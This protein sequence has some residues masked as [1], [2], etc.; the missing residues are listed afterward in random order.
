M[1]VKICG[2]SDIESARVAVKYGT[3]AIGFVFA[4]SK[5]KVTPEQAREIIQNIPFH[6]DKIGVFVNETREEI[7]RVIELAGLTAV[8]LH[9]DESPE[10]CTHFTV[11]VIKA[12]SIS[13]KEDLKKVDEYECDY[14]L[15]DSPRGNYHGGNGTSFD[16]SLLTQNQLKDKKVIL[17]G[18]LNLEN[19]EEAVRLT[20]PFMVDVSSGV[21]TDGKKDL[22]KIKDFIQKAK[23]S[24]EG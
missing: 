6:V 14:V 21:E 7:E 9:G 1:K 19:V 2:I 22:L 24:V 12:F 8:Q 16:W 5:R 23:S 10:F 11:P 3:D 17:A 4:K 20:Q 13:N 18:G 15:L